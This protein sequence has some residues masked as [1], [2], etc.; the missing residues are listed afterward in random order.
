[1]A[2][3][4]KLD[5]LIL[6]TTKT[7]CNLPKSTPNIATQLPHKLF[8]IEAFSF[9]NAYITCIGEEL[10]DALND[11]GRLGKIYRGLTKYIMAKHNGSTTL[12]EIIQAAC[13]HSP[14]TRTIALLKENKI[15]IKSFDTTFPS[16]Q[17]QIETIWKENI[18]KLNDTQQ[19]KKN[20]Y[21]K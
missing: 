14:I 20:K 8:G 6:S 19:Q 10:Q 17:T 1:M 5:K 16:E 13:Q 11:K 21:T 2:N 3:I 4:K 7:I 15:C 18:H 12:T 9:K